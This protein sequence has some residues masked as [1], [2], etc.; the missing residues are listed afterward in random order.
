M[1]VAYCY[2]P[3][4]VPYLTIEQI[5]IICALDIKGLGDYSTHVAAFGSKADIF[6][7]FFNHHFSS[8]YQ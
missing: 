3:L 2:L 5:P 8:K 1:T 6:I 4:F 7:R